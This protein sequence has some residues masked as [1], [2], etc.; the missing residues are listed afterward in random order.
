MNILPCS[1]SMFVFPKVLPGALDWAVSQLLSG[2]CQVA[3]HPK[4]PP[5]DVNGVG[6][7]GKGQAASQSKP[8]FEAMYIYIPYADKTCYP[9]LCLH[10]CVIYVNSIHGLRGLGTDTLFSHDTIMHLVPFGHFF[11]KIG[12]IDLNALDLPANQRSLTYSYSWSVSLCYVEYNPHSSLC[13]LYSVFQGVTIQRTLP[14]TS[15][16]TI[17][18]FDRLSPAL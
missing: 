13:K 9:E 16:C 5:S 8:S 15:C 11:V 12:H 17:R 6:L 7:L 1:L 14:V 10:E 4:L 2:L 18:K 3:R